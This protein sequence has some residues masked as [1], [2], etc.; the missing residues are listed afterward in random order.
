VQSTGD[1][2]CHLSVF[3]SNADHPK[4]D[5][6][7][8]GRDVAS[9]ALFIYSGIYSV[10]ENVRSIEE[11]VVHLS[12]NGNGFLLYSSP[13]AAAAARSPRFLTPL[14]TEKGLLSIIINIGRCHIETFGTTTPT[15]PGLLLHQPPLFVQC[16]LGAMILCRPCQSTTILVRPSGV[17]SAV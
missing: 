15:Q 6:R 9:V 11:L 12:A 5:S 8:V 7:S 17:F 14:V 3:G 16:G 1:R 2:R 13:R 4:R 10:M